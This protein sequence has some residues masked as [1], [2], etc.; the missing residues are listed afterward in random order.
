MPIE[1]TLAEKRPKRKTAAAVVDTNVAKE[2]KM[3]LDII[4][5]VRNVSIALDYFKSKHA[6]ELG[7]GAVHNL[8]IMVDPLDCIHEGGRS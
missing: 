4:S 1:I 5:Q 3:L 7:K 6:N 2:S 8:G